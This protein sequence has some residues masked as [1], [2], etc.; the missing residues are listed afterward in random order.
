VLW[1]RYEKKLYPN[2]DANRMRE[3]CFKG[4]WVLVALHH[5]L[6]FPETYGNLKAL[7]NVHGDRV[8][9]WTLGALLHKMRRFP[10]R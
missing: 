6:G 5:G 10:L 8:F 4:V 7:P 1:D 9:T 3:E 2:S